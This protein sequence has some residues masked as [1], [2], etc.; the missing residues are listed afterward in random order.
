MLDHLV[1]ATPSLADTVA[2]LTARGLT[3]VPGGPHIG[4]GTR[5]HL[6][7]FAGDAGIGAGAYLEVIGPDP[8]QP[9]PAA[10]RPFGVDGLRAPALVAW[11]AR[12]AP[13][14][15][16]AVAAARAAG[17]DPGP[18]GEMSRRR[19]DGVLLEWR[20]TMHDGPT[21]ALP[22]LIDWRD[23]P[24]PSASLPAGAVLE[25]FTVRHPDPRLVLAVL[26]T[27]GQPEGVPEVVEGT[28][29]LTATIRLADG[30]TLEL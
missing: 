3:T 28:T 26:D 21:G 6:A 27:I 14:L 20:L 16:D 2:D 30:S 9:T 1:Y 8:D 11:C 24:H 23:S 29:A 18:I 22:F 4:R 7:G 15:E 13:A 25:R 19:P 10:P 5:N 17:Y 12:P